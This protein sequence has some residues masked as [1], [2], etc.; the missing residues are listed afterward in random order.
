VP[1]CY[2]ESYIAPS[3]LIQIPK[4]SKPDRLN[5]PEACH[6]HYRNFSVSRYFDLSNTFAHCS[7]STSTT[8]RAIDS[9]SDCS[10][11]MSI[12]NAEPDATEFSYSVHPL[13]TFSV[14]FFHPMIVARDLDIAM[15]MQ[16]PKSNAPATP[17]RLMNRLTELTRLGNKPYR[18]KDG[19]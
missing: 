4:T 8:T 5:R 12:V 11:Q 14:Y 3:V 16:I 15:W 9:R 1:D 18:R 2:A 10:G 6:N 13:Y 7:P 19:H 17:P